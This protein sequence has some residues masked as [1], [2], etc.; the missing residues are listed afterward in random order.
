MESI[1]IDPMEELVIQKAHYT[2]FS[3]ERLLQVL[4][5]ALLIL[6]KSITDVFESPN[7]AYYCGNIYPWYYSASSLLDLSGTSPISCT[8][9]PAECTA[10]HYYQDKVTINVPID[11]VTEV[12]YEGYTQ[13]GINKL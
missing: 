7:V 9:K 2:G 6:I 5:M 3:A 11:N 4:F 12:S 1:E 8:N 10:D 13:Y